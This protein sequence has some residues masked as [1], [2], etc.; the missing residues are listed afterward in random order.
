MVKYLSFVRNAYDA[1]PEPRQLTREEIQSAF[2]LTDEEAELLGKLVF[3]DNS[4]P[5]A[6]GG[7]LGK[8]WRAQLPREPWRVVQPD[9]PRISTKGWRKDHFYD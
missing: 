5:F 6:G 2:E 9:L 3:F 7:A 8:E 4:F 1:N